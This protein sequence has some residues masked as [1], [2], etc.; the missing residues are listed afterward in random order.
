[1]NGSDEMQRY[2][3]ISKIDNR[4]ILEE[5]DYHHIK[6]VMRNSDGDLIE[7]VIDN[8]LYLGCIENVKSNIN[9][10]IKKELEIESDFIPN[11][12]LII[13]ILKEQKMDL[14]LQ[15]SCEMGVSKITIIPLKRCIVKVNDKKTKSKIDRWNRILKEASE[16][17][18]RNYIPDLK[19]IDSINELEKL[20]GLK[21]V[22]STKKNLNNIKRVLTENKNCDTINV[23]IGPEGGLDEIEEKALNEYGFISTTFGSRI[24]RVESVPLFI[25]SVIN[26]EYMEW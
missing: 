8:K 22:C 20:D 2:F 24:L 11:V 17:S 6:N 21:I 23:V 26:Y 1:M 18:F 19:L 16:Q 4:L 3:G 12:N 13:P 9:V 5:S 14:I 10:L 25:M 7:V 15:K